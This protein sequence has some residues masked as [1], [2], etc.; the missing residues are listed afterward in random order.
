MPNSLITRLPLDRRTEIL[1]KISRN[2]QALRGYF[3]PNSAYDAAKKGRLDSLQAL[4][5]RGI[6]P[7]HAQQTA[8]TVTLHCAVQAY[9]TA[10]AGG[11]TVT[12]VSGAYSKAFAN[13]SNTDDATLAA[14]GVVDFTATDSLD[15][16]AT[17]A[18]RA[19]IA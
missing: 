6:I 8:P 10:R 7:I 18:A 2:S 5:N 17:G 4:L 19:L 14:P 1:R 12:V 16:N 15:A 11:D 3:R 13:P 9:P